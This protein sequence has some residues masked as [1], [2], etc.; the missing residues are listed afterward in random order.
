[1]SRSKPDARPYQVQGRDWLVDVER[2]FLGDEPGLGKSRQLIEAARGTT[3]VVAPAM[4]LDG[5]TWDDEIEKWGDPRNPTFQR[6][7][8]KLNLR[9]PSGKT[10]TTGNAVYTVTTG[11]SDAV[12]Q[13]GR[14]QTLILDEVHLAKGRNTLWT[15]VIRRLAKDADRVYLATGTPI[16]NWPHELFVPLQLMFPEEAKP[17]GTFGAYWRWIDEWFHTAPNRFGDAHS[18]PD[19]MGLRRCNSKCDERPPYDPCDHFLEFASGNLR[20]RFMQRKRDDVLG[21]LP[22]LTGPVRVEVPMTPVQWREYKAMRDEYVA[23]MVDGS[24]IVAWSA[25]AK[26]VMLDRLTTGLGVVTNEWTTAESGK[27]KRLEYDLTARARPT[28]VVAH[29]RASVE[30]AAAVAQSVGAVTR[31]IHGGTTTKQRQEVVRAFQAGKVDVLCGSLETVAEGLN[32]VAA[33]LGISLEASYKPSRNE[34]AINR[35]RRMGQVRPT[36]WLDYVSVSPTGRKTLDVNK[37][38]LL[39]R[40]TDLQMR[41]L[42]AAQFASLL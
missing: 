13:I 9:K 20:D 42:T 30:A 18:N 40:K 4:V 36:T 27:L 37:R 17:G 28:L 41:V 22:P 7:Y 35:I 19:I 8:S 26:N 25:A 14:V 11:M 5:G 3:L 10:S 32:L 6:A 24:E 12:K 31:V 16:P 1:M 2:G 23:S 38:E 34:Q 29:Y 15:K 33:D 39:A 21:D